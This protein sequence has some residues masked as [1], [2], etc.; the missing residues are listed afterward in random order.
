MNRLVSNSE[1]GTRNSEWIGTSPHRR[2]R[3]F[4]HALICFVTLFLFN[5]PA[6]GAVMTNA[7][8]LAIKGK[9]EV[10]RAGAATWSAASTNQ[11]L[12]AGDRVRTGER[13][14]A[15]LRVS[16]KTMKRL[17]ERTL[18]QVQPGRGGK[19]LRGLFYFFHRDEP[20]TFPIETPSAYAVIIGTEFSVE[21]ADNDAT[22]LHVIDGRVDG[23]GASG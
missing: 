23:A 5:G 16:D 20:G 3:H 12:A 14:W 6:R 7:A 15:V 4:E 1:I 21:V 2:P 18:Y 8:V 11:P 22:T 10:S 13:S 9:V 19:L 17:G